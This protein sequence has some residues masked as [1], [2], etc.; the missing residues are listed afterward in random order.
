[1]EQVGAV[2]SAKD[3]LVYDVVYNLDQE[4]QEDKFKRLQHDSR[5]RLIRYKELID[6]LSVKGIKAGED[7]VLQAAF[8]DGY[9]GGCDSCEEYLNMEQIMSLGGQ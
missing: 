6:E 2:P 4:D 8:D 7:W 3:P 5:V 9:E 1:M